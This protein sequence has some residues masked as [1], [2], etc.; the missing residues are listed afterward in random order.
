MH[1]N[2]EIKARSG[3]ND[4]IREILRREGADFRGLDHQIDTYFRV[5]DGRLKLREGNIEHSL[6]FYQRPDQ[7]GPKT[8]QVHLYHPK[9]GPELKQLLIASLG[10]WK[11]V[12][13]QREIAFIGN[14]KF[15][16]DRVAGL[17]EFMEIEAI[18]MEG[19]GDVTAL[20]K[21]CD[22]YMALFGVE[23]KDLLSNSYS[24]LVKEEGE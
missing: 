4:R 1:L 21:Q 3:H 7:A 11:V 2:V 16:L 17:G 13:K 15:H 14:V 20:Q 9:P 18:D 22:H 12:D 8:S 19:H 23:R 10:V 24:D 5:A 6:I